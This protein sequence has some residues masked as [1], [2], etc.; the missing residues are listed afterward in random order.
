MFKGGG[1]LRSTGPVRSLA[2]SIIQSYPP[3]ASNNTFHARAQSFMLVS[4]LTLSASLNATGK[5]V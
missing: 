4:I 3:C 2:K 5:A 1:A